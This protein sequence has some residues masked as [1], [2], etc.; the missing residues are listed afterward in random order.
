[1]SSNRSVPSTSGDQNQ[2]ASFQDVLHTELGQIA[3]R[4]ARHGLVAAEAERAAVA[5]PLADLIL[6]AH[7]KRLVGLAFSGGGIRSATFNLGLLQGLAKL[8]LLPFIDYLSTVSGGSYIGSWF[9]TWVWR[10]RDQGGLR[11]VQKRLEPDCPQNNPPPPG[12]AEVLAPIQH[13]RTYSNYL[14][15]R[16]GVLS[17]D[18]WV[19]WAGYVR[20]FLL[21]Q[22]VLL[23]L[24]VAVLIVP[25][26][27]MLG[28]YDNAVDQEV[29]GETLGVV[30]VLVALFGGFAQVWAVHGV[31]L[32]R[33]REDTRGA[34]K[35]TAIKPKRLLITIALPRFVAACLFCGLA[36]HRLGLGRWMV[37][38][39]GEEAR[40]AWWAD[41][42]ALSGFVAALLAMAI[43]IVWLWHRLKYHNTT[44][45][46][47]LV[48]LGSIATGAVGGALLYGSYALLHAF[49]T[50]DFIKQRDYAR[51]EAT[52]H[53]TTLGPP[54][55]LATIC[56]TLFLAIAILHRQLGEELREWWSSMCARLV[57]LAL[58]WLSVHLVALYGTVLVMQAEPWL[59]VALGS[60]WLLT[61]VLGVLGGKG[62][63]TGAGGGQNR[64]V[65]WMAYLAPHLF[66]VGFIIVVSL[67]IS[68]VIDNQP[69]WR[70][71][72]ESTWHRLPD[73]ALPAV[74]I[75]VS[76]T[77]GGGGKGP[78]EQRQETTNRAEIADKGRIAAH[79]YWVGM[80]NKEPNFKPR[81][82]YILSQHTL[83]VMEKSN[84]DKQWLAL[85][86]RERLSDDELTWEQFAAILNR[87]LPATVPGE[88]RARIVQAAKH[89]QTM[90]ECDACVFWKLA[91]CLAG[92]L[93][94]T[95][96]FAWCVDVNV[97]SL[98]AIYANRLTRCYLGASRRRKPDPVTQ[99][100][101]NDDE[102]LAR[103]TIDA[104]TGYDGPYPIINT[105]MNL[106][107]AQRLDWQQRRAESFILTPS[108]CGSQTTGYRPTA[109][110]GKR[111]GYGGNVGLGTAVGISG[112]AAS[113]NMG[114]HSSPAV[115]AL[116]TVFN[117]RLGAW[118]GN[119][120]NERCWDRAGPRFGFLYLLRELFGW[121][122]AR[123]PRV[124][125]SDG[126]HFENLG[127]Y[128]LVR[129][130]CQ[131]IIV[132]DA[133][134]DPEHAFADFG[135]L[136]RK[137]RVDL[138]IR[139]EIDLDTL[140][141]PAGGRCQWHCAVGKIRYDDAD[142]A[143][144]VGTL[145]Y[146]KPCLT[147]DEPS[148]V[149][150]YAASHAA[151]PHEATAN[152]F[153]NEAQF[154]SYRALGQHV[155]TMVFRQSEQDMREF[156]DKVTE[157]NKTHRRRCRALFASL[158]RRWFAMP[159]QYEATFVTALQG[160]VDLQASMRQDPELCRLTFDLY[161]ELDR[162]SRDAEGPVEDAAQQDRREAA[163]LHAILQMLQLMESAWLSLQL[164]VHFAHPLNRG[165]MGIFHRWTNAP[166]VRRLWPLLR[167]ELARGF[168]SFC[169]KQM[170]LG[171][172]QGCA[173]PIA[174][175]SV[176]GRRLDRLLLEL[177]DQ[178]EEK[179]PYVEEH[180]DKVGADGYLGW[181]VMTKNSYPEE[182]RVA[183]NQLPCGIILVSPENVPQGQVAAYDLFV[184]MR[185]AYRNTGIGQPAVE[186]VIDDLR[187]LSSGQA[188]R[189]HV[190]LPAGKLSGPGGDVQ[191]SMW[192]TFFT[193]HE[194]DRTPDAPGGQE[195]ELVLE[196]EF[197]AVAE[198]PEPRDQNEQATGSSARSRLD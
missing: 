8:N 118:L 159:P 54:L 40:H 158:V 98:Q 45:L 1:M 88:Q 168:V 28:Y 106:V 145:I 167:G 125:L 44:G 52:A 154:E 160:F 13:L 109:P 23:P 92:C 82:Y 17:T 93:L 135:N 16:S 161:P 137:C 138:G 67:L 173:E 99:M 47:P 114:Y 41:M 111:Q 141:R 26:L 124:Y 6:E 150:H 146:L 144:P 180:L 12:S 123:A 56:V 149:L 197:N 69:D 119:P 24:L 195:G 7:K 143:A 61:T 21:N 100:D 142:P 91:G 89:V 66:L 183:A 172:V 196:R 75:T 90:A 139:L 115:T 97:F 133:G 177:R 176:L 50:G 192:Y 117:A 33:L 165:W 188:F 46:G 101:P 4:R 77:T 62:S 31:N 51:V 43:A 95:A 36:P 34:D 38:F 83:A 134:C 175:R 190:R 22:L 29:R 166:T 169:E 186:Q 96:F 79:M 179:M 86:R 49:Y 9:A 198:P 155:A 110:A 151:F 178:W 112:A 10:N 132:S 72:P 78:V 147:G 187:R 3:A 163:E 181:L 108:Y 80:L 57:I 85:L 5:P 156:M 35:G 162:P 48:A 157:I 94:A 174:R 73:T 130:R 148:D 184:W 20:N 189:L 39:L 170:R 42:L 25:R 65:E 64:L 193:H 107:H 105:A 84:V 122:H 116:L 14:T 59:Q 32:V 15:P 27:F 182:P 120:A 11:E 164:D 19:L 37:D 70:A 113:P 185:G 60:G 2:V 140:R 81:D 30:A 131:Y 104:K 53:L 103:L 71:A 153:Y 63:A 102:L 126:G 194:F 129:R 87:L 121:T 68:I 74:Q 152:Q 136:V 191:I 76:T 127:V 55:V 58:I 18:F 128:E 171:V